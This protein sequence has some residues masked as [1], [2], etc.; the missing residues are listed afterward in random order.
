MATLEAGQ[1][2]ALNEFLNQHQTRAY[3]MT[4]AMISNRDDALELVQDAMLKLVQNYANKR[5]D[6]WP[7]LFFRILQN[8]IRDYHRGSPLRNLFRHWFSDT[9]N[10]GDESPQFA[11]PQQ[12]SPEQH[13][14]HENSLEQIIQAI[15][16]LPL[17]QQ[18]TFLLRAWQGFSVSETAFALEISEGSVKTHYSRAQNRLRAIIGD[19]S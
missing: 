17:R 5:S 4:Y 11:D 13:V 10:E 9:A 18:Q 2:H 15:H 19:Q 3:Q 12:T 14:Q 7:L 1:K 8:R 16:S 6:E